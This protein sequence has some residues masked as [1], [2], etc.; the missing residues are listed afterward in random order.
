[1][2]GP[3]RVLTVDDEP[4]ALLRLRALLGED[5]EIKLVG[6]CANGREAI[7]AIRAQSPHLVFLDVKMPR[8]SG[9][10][11]LK[12]LDPG[13]IPLVIFVTAYQKYAVRAFEVHAVEYL[14]KPFTDERFREALHYAKHTLRTR[15]S[16]EINQRTRGLLES[17]N[18]P[19]LK[20]LRVK[21]KGVQVFIK[22]ADVEWIKAED[23]Y[24]SLRARGKSYLHREAI[25]KLE[26]QLDPKQFVAIHRSAIINIEFAASI[27]PSLRH[28]YQVVMLDGTRLP[29]SNSARKRLGWDT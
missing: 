26:E 13:K 2:K 25:S 6:E 8:I 22:V 19:Y 17:F 7:E 16:D 28:G 23:K 29:I 10:D 15:S 14:L 5:P 18:T 4:D 21:E 1:M 20:H 3:I 24:V 9:F 12:A 27:E 11:V